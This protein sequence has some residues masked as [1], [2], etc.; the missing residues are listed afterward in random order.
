M[1]GFRADYEYSQ[2]YKGDFTDGGEGGCEGGEFESGGGEAG[3]DYEWG[4]G[5]EYG[6]G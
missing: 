5:E 4:G 6:G 1:D 3:Y 2:D